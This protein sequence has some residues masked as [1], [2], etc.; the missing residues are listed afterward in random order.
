MFLV[1]LSFPNDLK[2]LFLIDDSAV[3]LKW[4]GL[5]KI[6]NNFFHYCYYNYNNKLFY[7]CYCCCHKYCKFYYLILFK[8]QLFYSVFTSMSSGTFI[9]FSLHVSLVNDLLILGYSITT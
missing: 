3:V 4:I 2:L 7:N 9:F 1:R 8:L 6:L 5:V